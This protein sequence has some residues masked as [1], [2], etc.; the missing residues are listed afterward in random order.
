MS[1][2][3]TTTDIKTRSTTRALLRF[4][5]NVLPAEFA[6]QVLTS[7][8]ITDAGSYDLSRA[9]FSGLTV[10]TCQAYAAEAARIRLRRQESDRA[11][12]PA[13]PRRPSA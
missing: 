11:R 2:I 3:I 1:A 6:T 5:Q 12:S 8:T 9:V 10:S 13:S 4:G 7:V